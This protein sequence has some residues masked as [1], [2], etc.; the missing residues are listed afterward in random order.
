MQ[1]AHGVNPSV[2]ASSS[3]SGIAVPA[4]QAAAAGEVVAR[5]LVDD[6]HLVLEVDHQ[7]QVGDL[8]LLDGRVL[9]VRGR[10]GSTSPAPAAGG[11]CAASARRRLGVGGTASAAGPPARLSG[12]AAAAGRSARDADVLVGDAPVPAPSAGA[13]GSAWRSAGGR[14][15]AAPRRRTQAATHTQ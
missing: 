8:D 9:Q 13:R 12:L 11:A 1:S 4:G 15:T 14:R 10:R 2:R 5:V 6:E 3:G 7:Q